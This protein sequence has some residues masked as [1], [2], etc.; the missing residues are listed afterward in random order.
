LILADECYSE[1]WRDT[2]PPGALKVATDMELPDR[3]VMFNSLSKR[4]NLPGLRSG[5]AAG[6]VAQ[7]RELRRLRSYAGAPLPL[8][9]QRVSE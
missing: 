1:I 4:S 2:P 7:I 5:F 9:V 8:P 6:G 3:V